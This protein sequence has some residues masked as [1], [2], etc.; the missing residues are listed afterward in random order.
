[1]EKLNYFPKVITWKWKSEFEP[2]F[3]SSEP[4]IILSISGITSILMRYCFKSQ[5]TLSLDIEI[6]TKTWTN[7]Q[8][9]LFCES[10]T[11]FLRLTSVIVSPAPSGTLLS[12]PSHPMYYI[13]YITLYHMGLAKKFISVF[14]AAYG[15]NQTNFLANPIFPNKSPSP[16]I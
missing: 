12:S 16:I 15:K 10:W 7:L 4:V 6:S 1:M 3:E 14:V 13:L 5:G 8:P 11:L 2:S 9:L